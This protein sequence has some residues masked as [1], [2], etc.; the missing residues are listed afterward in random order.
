MELLNPGTIIQE[1]YRIE[2]FLHKSTF[3][4]IYK[5]K[6]LRF[7]VKWWAVKEFILRPNDIE[8]EKEI[9]ERFVKICKNISLLHFKSL[10]KV[11]DYFYVGNRLYLVTEYV[12]GRS[13]KEI[14][15]SDTILFHEYQAISLGIQ[16]VNLIDYLNS[17]MEKLAVYPNFQLTNIIV[18]SK[19]EIK[20]VDLGLSNIFAG[21]RVNPAQ[22]ISMGYGAPEIYNE[23]FEINNKSWIYSIGVVMHQML[24]RR[25]PEE[26]PFVFPFVTQ[27][28]PSISVT[29]G[30]IIAKALAASPLDRFGSLKEFKEE[31]IKQSQEI[32]QARN[33]WLSFQAKLHSQKNVN[34]FDD[35]DNKE[36][37]INDK[38]YAPS[39]QEVL[40]WGA[41]IALVSLL[42]LLGVFLFYYF[43]K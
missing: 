7:P 12:E 1:R 37:Y 25:S 9:K 5:V 16:L 29:T 28:N 40:Y 22:Q 39:W 23:K 24:T 6:D 4:G 8:R 3:G 38:L 14:L 34:E 15:E 31:L 27:F 18:T 10:P 26:E 43:K 19:G 21:E 42:S 13:L 35:F 36:I 30:N 32:K 20:L 2:K 11:V 41:I 33:H 17:Y